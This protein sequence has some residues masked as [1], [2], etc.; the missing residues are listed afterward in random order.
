MDKNKLFFI[1]FGLLIIGSVSA[2]YYRFMIAK[3]YIIEAEKEC[4]PY[5]EACFV[6][7]C[8][9]EAGEE[10]T[11]DPEEDTWY[12]KLIRRKAKNI[13][14]CD[15]NDENCDVL[16]CQ[17]GEEECE[18][19]LCNDAVLSEMG[20]ETGTCTDPVIYTHENPINEEDEG[21]QTEEEA[22]GNS[23]AG[24]L[25]DEENRDEQ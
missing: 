13:P 21:I 19:T 12:Y 10:C 22:V 2:S 18:E 5:S 7:V 8:D 11:G 15:P 23:E 9:P 25:T 1:V 6:Y 14:L 17:E 16:T 24:V 4:D 20:E 3:N